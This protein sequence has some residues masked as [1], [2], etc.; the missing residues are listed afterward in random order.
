MIYVFVV[1]LI[2]GLLVGGFIGVAMMAIVSYASSGDYDIDHVA[3]KEDEN[4]T[5]LSDDIRGD[6]QG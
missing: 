5:V 2:V 3:A 1:G 4:D 6:V